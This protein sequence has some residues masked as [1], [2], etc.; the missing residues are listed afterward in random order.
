MGWGLLILL[1]CCCCFGEVPPFNLVLLE[2]KTA[3]AAGALCLDGSSPGYHID[4]RNTS[5]LLLFLQ[6]GAW[7][8]S[9]ESCASRAKT[10]LGS[11]LS[12]PKVSSPAHGMFDASPEVNPFFHDFTKVYVLYCDGGAFSGDR[13]EELK[14]PG[15]EVLY[16]RG[17][18][19]LTHL[20]NNI[21]VKLSSSSLSEVLLTGCSAG[22]Q[23][24]LLQGDYVRSLLP[25]G[26]RYGVIPIAGHFLDLPSLGGSR[27]FSLLMNKTALLHNASS[28]SFPSSLLPE[29]VFPH[30][31][32][33]VFIHMPLYDTWSLLNLML[34]PSASSSSEWRSCISSLS[35][36]SSLH[37]Q[38]MHARWTHELLRSVLSSSA[39]W[40]PDHG[41]FF[42][43]VLTH[44]G[45]LG[46]PWTQERVG[47]VA[48]AV[49]WG[50]WFYDLSTIN[51]H[52]G[53]LLH[54]TPPYQCNQ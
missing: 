25:S 45:V 9:A 39:F 37:I 34:G 47:G 29:A 22:G 7:C 1:S 17:R 50:Q 5:K 43:S 33:R 49:A 15:G 24:A 46:D 19:I 2:E 41:C 40:R 20:I 32:S 35:S 4:V 14:G 38:T 36:C 18:R 42:S 10:P 54:E 13:Q 6:G 31:A 21:L 44:C 26:I 52:F 27:E 51:R 30:V 8:D 28:S 11:S 3:R 12:W 48:A 16:L 53:C 23:A